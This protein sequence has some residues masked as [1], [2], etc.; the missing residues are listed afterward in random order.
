MIEVDI[1]G[2][3]VVRL[4]HLVLDVNGTIACDG[5]LLPGVVEALR[6]LRDVVSVVA[7]TADTHGTARGLE[8]AAG[9]QVQVIARGGE[10]EQKLRLVQE[11][12]ADEVVAI[13]NGANDAGMLE[14]AALGVCVIGPE[15]AA[16]QAVLA[17]DVVV[18]SIVDALDLLRAP[19]RLVATLR[20]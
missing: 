16:T 4:R 19:R 15:G 7:V 10:T 1:P 2:R 8:A 11:L 12:G 14:A 13:G 6:D 3:G 17:S 18:T 5:V 9:V 20:R